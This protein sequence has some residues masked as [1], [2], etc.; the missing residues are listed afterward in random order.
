MRF[1]LRGL[2]GLGLIVLAATLAVM[3]ALQL[4]ETLREPSAAAR[5]A[6][7]ERVYV[8]STAVLER[9]TA[10]PV[11]ETHGTVRSWRT[12][13]L[14]AAVAGRVVGMAE[15]FRD[16]ARVGR[17]DVLLRIDPADFE[18]RVAEAEA[19]LAE[20][21][22][23][24]DEAEQAVTAAE[25]ERQAAETQRALRAASL[26]RQ[27][28][29][30]ARG[31]V[32]GT[33]VEEAELALAAARQAVAGQGQAVVAAG[34]R[35]QRA[36]IAVRRADL[37]LAE[38]QRDLAD[39]VIRAPFDGVIAEAGAGLGDLVAVNESVGLLIDPIA[40]EV[41]F[42]VTNTQ[43]A[44]LLEADGS[45]RPLPVTV[46]LP[47]GDVAQVVTGRLDRPGARVGAGRTGRE[48][49]AR[50]DPKP[51]LPLKPDDFVTVRLQEPP[52]ADVAVVPAAAVSEA[53]DLLVLGPDDRLAVVAVTVL[54]REGDRAILADVPF[55]ATY[56]TERSPQLAP[57]LRARSR[58]AA[59]PSGDDT[60]FVETP[61]RLALA[62]PRHNAALAGTRMA[63]R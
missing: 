33:A 53:G 49:F 50:L 43:H 52:L 34:L 19:A 26:A 56:V 45:L 6:P 13:D 44:R 11:I 9:V 24:V 28:D 35:V 48:L 25:I 47:V 58:S 7:Q 57:G 62:I 32:S 63:D 55:G 60:V 61:S 5:Q 3:A 17:G 29:L 16:G 59:A 4:A 31:V 2:S 15:R 38:A 22:A 54:R 42:R 1:V 20:A 21:R 8:V 46:M 12:L 14:R 37:A 23:D 51:D 41:A 39:T 30:A 27:R 10:R 40:L 36:A 18:T